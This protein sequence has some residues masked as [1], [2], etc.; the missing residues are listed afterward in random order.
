VVIDPL[1][2]VIDVGLSLPRMGF[3]PTRARVFEALGPPLD[4]IAAELAAGRQLSAA[5]KALIIALVRAT[6]EVFATA[7]P[8]GSSVDTRG[9]LQAASVALSDLQHD[10]AGSLTRHQDQAAV[11]AP[12]LRALSGHGDAPAVAAPSTGWVPTRGE[13]PG[14]ESMVSLARTLAE[15]VIRLEETFAAASLTPG[16]QPGATTLPPGA[17]LTPG[18]QPGATTLPPGTSLNPGAQ[19]GAVTPLPGASLN[20][21]A[22]PAETTPLADTGTPARMMLPQTDRPVAGQTT[23]PTEHLDRSDAVHWLLDAAV[24]NAAR[25]DQTLA[26]QSRQGRVATLVRCLIDDFAS[27]GRA[28][29]SATPPGVFLEVAASAVQSGQGGAAVLDRYPVLVQL[30]S[31]IAYE[32]GMAAGSDEQAE[33]VAF[34]TAFARAQLLVSALIA[35]AEKGDGPAVTSQLWANLRAAGMPAFSLPADSP[36]N[37]DS[38]R[39]LL[40]AAFYSRAPDRRRVMPRTRIPRCDRCGRMMKRTRAGGLICTNC[41]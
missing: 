11:L 38:L 19:P 18:A 37:L 27:A 28:G 20:P 32:L 33:A 4:R 41:L 6:L 29:A 7:L 23:S 15:A 14:A 35:E 26:S 24:T 25:P 9:I 12:I 17:S 10:L 5:Q 40:V 31:A 34:S 8:T 21:G 13:P 2:P 1:R 22:Q 39:W 3:A 36:N 30:L 16:A